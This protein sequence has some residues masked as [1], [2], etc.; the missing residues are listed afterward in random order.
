LEAREDQARRELDVVKKE[1]ERL[2]DKNSEFAIALKQANDEMRAL[3]AENERLKEKIN[4]YEKTFPL[5]LT[6]FKRQVPP[7][8]IS[9]EPTQVNE[10]NHH[11]TPEISTANTGKRR[12][13]KEYHEIM[14]DIK[15][16]QERFS[17][18]SV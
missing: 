5:S 4:F 11:Q 15:R 1:K 14:Q 2:V 9:S 12:D 3:R 7:L 17:E 18:K 8:N 6:K 10:Q 16:E 13:F